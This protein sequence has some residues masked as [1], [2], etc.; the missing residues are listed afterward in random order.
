MR[1]PAK[2]WKPVPVDRI[3]DPGA[4]NERVKSRFGRGDWSV[5]D[6]AAVVADQPVFDLPLECIDLGGHDFGTDGGLLGFARHMRHVLDC[7]TSVPVILDEWGG[8]IDGRHRVVR[9]LID[10]LATVPARRVPSGT[11]PTSA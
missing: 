6:L 7:D 10:G 3:W 11:Q 5:T 1:T 2:S 9:A 4:R 8:L